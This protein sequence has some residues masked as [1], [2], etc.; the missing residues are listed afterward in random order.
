MDTVTV[1][2]NG[3]ELDVSG[4]YSKMVPSRN[5]SVEPDSEAEF[6]VLKIKVGG[7]DIMP[8]FSNS[9]LTRITEMALDAMEDNTPR[10]VRRS[11]LTG[12]FL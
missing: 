11:A 8:V 6:E 3:V 2:F 9:Q 10:P 7:V 1:E 5:I 12:A 4:F